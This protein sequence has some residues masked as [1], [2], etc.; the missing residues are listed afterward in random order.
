MY[1]W[2]VKYYK[3]GIGM[4]WAGLVKSV[5]LYHIQIRFLYFYGSRYAFFGH[6]AKF[7]LVLLVSPVNDGK[8]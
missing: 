6:F 8:H 4:G 2:T 7:I 1:A 5:A 3:S